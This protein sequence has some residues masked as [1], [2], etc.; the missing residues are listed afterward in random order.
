MYSEGNIVPDHEKRLESEATESAFKSTSAPEIEGW[1]AGEDLDLGMPASE[2]LRQE[3]H[4]LVKNRSLQD[5]L[6]QLPSL[7]MAGKI[8]ASQTWNS[9]I[10]L[11][12]CEV[13]ISREKILHLWMREQFL[14]KTFTKALKLKNASADCNLKPRVLTVREYLHGTAAGLRFSSK[15]LSSTCAAISY[16]LWT[17]QIVP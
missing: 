9:A 15:K 4:R 11:K 5:R 10:Q 7:L 1:D 17:R 3:L 14:V 13:P 8:P 2:H 12:D 6:V 16:G